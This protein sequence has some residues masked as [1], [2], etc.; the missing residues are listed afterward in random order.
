[1]GLFLDH[2]NVCLSKLRADPI[3]SLSTDASS[4]AF[5]A[6]VAVNRAVRRIWNYAQWTFK[7]RTDTFNTAVNQS[8]YILGKS[9][10]QPYSIMSANPPYL[11]KLVSRFTLDKQDPQRTDVGDPRLV[12]VSDLSPVSLQPLAASIIEV[13]SSSA[14]DTTQKVLIRG[15]VSGEEDFEQVS[16]NGVTGIFTSKQFSS[17]LSLSKSDITAGEIT[18][19][20]GAR[21]LDIIGPTEKVVNRRVLSLYPIPQAV[22]LM[23]IRHFTKAPNLISEYDWTRIPEDWDYIVDQWAFVLALQAKGQDQSTEFSNQ[24][25]LAA[26]MLE[27]DMNTEEED[28]SD[29]TIL[30]DDAGKVPDTEVVWP[31]PGQGYMGQ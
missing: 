21:T 29:E 26:K 16:L 28:A 1:M 25:L 12:A 22:I 30:I 23:T 3:T 14:A 11:M 4:D 10:G 5:K 7:R 19:R 13:L 17:I 6:Q 31:P 27:Q 24:L 8:E 18:V 9:I 15:I 20:I 2:V